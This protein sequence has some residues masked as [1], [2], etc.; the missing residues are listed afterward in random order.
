VSGCVRETVN[1]REIKNLICWK[2][3]P[4]ASDSRDRGKCFAYFSLEIIGPY[5]WGRDMGDRLMG[6]HC[7]RVSSRASRATH[8]LTQAK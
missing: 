3:V 2:F 5:K 8:L 7:R 1:A 4:N 6:R